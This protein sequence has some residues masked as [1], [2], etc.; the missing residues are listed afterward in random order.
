MRIQTMSDNDT[1]RGRPD[2]QRAESHAIWDDSAAAF[3]R[4][5][6][7]DPGAMDELVHTMTPVL[8]QV[9][10]AYGLAQDQAQDV[11]QTTWLALVQRSGAIA[12]PHAIAAWLLTTARREAWRVSKS[13]STSIS[14]SDEVLEAV[15]EVQS[16]AEDVALARD[17]ESR[18]WACVRRQSERCQRLLRI[19]AFEQRPDYAKIARDLGMPVGSIGPTRGRCLSKLREA[20]EQMEGAR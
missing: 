8:W 20:I 12:D 9:V 7:G 14:V 3:S 15:T 13:S 11:V 10:R 16:S 2:G 17:G 4:W 5:L 6:S 1:V 18:L 19:V